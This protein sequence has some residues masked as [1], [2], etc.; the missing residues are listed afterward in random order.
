MLKSHGFPK[1]DPVRHPAYNLTKRFQYFEKFSIFFNFLEILVNTKPLSIC[2]RWTF[3]SSIS[4]FKKYYVI[5]EIKINKFL[6][7]QQFLNFLH[8]QAQNLA[9][10]KKI[11]NSHYNN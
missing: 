7:F 1:K 6:Y 9:L 11:W 3:L 10:R 5:L 8:S 2:R 4:Y